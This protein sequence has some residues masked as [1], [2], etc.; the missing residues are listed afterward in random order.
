MKCDNCKITIVGKPS[1]YE[2]ELPNKKFCS[3][4]CINLA[5]YNH[6][7]NKKIKPYTLVRTRTFVF[8]LNHSKYI[9]GIISNFD[10]KLGR[11]KTFVNKYYCMSHY[12]T[13]S[14]DAMREFTDEQSQ[15]VYHQQLADHYLQ[16][17]QNE[18]EKTN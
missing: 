13:P 2:D 15:A 12:I 10:K 16:V 4:T 5:W 7:K 9:Y 1:T 17:T 18:E 11:G 3:K 8:P 6:L 14:E